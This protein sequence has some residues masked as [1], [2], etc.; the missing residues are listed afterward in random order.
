MKKIYL[1]CD[2]GMSTSMLA[3]QMQNIGEK[4]KLELE[5]KAFPIRN[6]EKILEEKHPDCVLLG[7]QVRHLFEDA[8]KRVAPFD[9][10]VGV[11]DSA[12]YGMMDGEKVLKKTI[13]LMKKFKQEKGSK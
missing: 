11:I 3:Q 4:H 2:N 5:V 6:L 7:P 9:V 8:K 12:D 1:F 13:L 10:P